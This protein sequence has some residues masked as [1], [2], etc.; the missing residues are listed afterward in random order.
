MSLQRVDL[1]EFRKVS[2]VPSSDG[3]AKVHGVVRGLT[4]MRRGKREYFAALLCDNSKRLRIHG[5][6]SLIRERLVPFQWENKAVM[7][8]GCQVMKNKSTGEVEL[9]LGS[10]VKVAPSSEAFSVDVIEERKVLTLSE[11]SG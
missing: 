1:G 10:N 2:D 9:R 11:V 4:P 7:L 8:S 5:F 3:T 6:D